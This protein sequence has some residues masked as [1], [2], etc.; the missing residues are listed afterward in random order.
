M[1]Q[2]AKLNLRDKD[3]PNSLRQRVKLYNQ[4]AGEIENYL[5]K[6]P[7]EWGRF[8]SQFNSELNVVY[9]E[10]VNFEKENVAK[11]NEDKIYRLKNLFV[12]K[13]RKYFLR[14]EYVTWSFN[15]P[16]GYAGDYK[17]IDD[18][19]LNHPKTIGFDRL[20]DNYF[21]MS[22]IS[23][24]VRNRKEDF[25]RFICNF[26]ADVRNKNQNLK[27]MD[28]ACG[29][30]R[31]VKELLSENS[32]GLFNNVHFDCFDADQR[33]IDYSK[34]LLGPLGRQVNFTQMNIIKLALA[35][36][37]ENNIAVKY[38]IIFSTGLFDYLDTRI[39]IRFIQNLSKLL[40]TGGILAI[41]DV[42]DK[43][44]NPSIYFMEWVADWSLIYRDDDDF[45]NLF[46]KAGFSRNQLV[47]G[48]EQQGIMQYVIASKSK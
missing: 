1:N 20:Y 32:R 34:K 22:S 11:D 29:P 38:D 27:I 30:S 12:R 8:Q 18:I 5:S 14:G 21:Q 16:F 17:I 19:Y 3:F 42:R 13:L 15:K 26:L 28:L 25:K 39:S 10:I 41:S 43:Y 46:L 37:I 44:S 6:N 33:A 9:R 23:V 35:K 4:I 31:D 40:K 2:L 45:R 7:H 48:Y 47:T 24:A 36:E